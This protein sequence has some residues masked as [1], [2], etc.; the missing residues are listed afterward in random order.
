MREPRD[1]YMDRDLLDKALDSCDLG[2]GYT[3]KVRQFPHKDMLHQLVHVR[4]IRDYEHVLTGAQLE[5]LLR[6]VATGEKSDV[7]AL[8]EVLKKNLHRE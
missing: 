6:E 8:I 1:F 3:A 2:D 4:E 7:D 5:R